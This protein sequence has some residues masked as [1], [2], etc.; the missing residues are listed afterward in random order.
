MVYV[1]QLMNFGWAM[2]GRSVPNCHLV[3]DTL[4]ELHTFAGKIGM[5][6]EW[7]QDKSIPHYDL[8]PARRAAAVARGAV[9]LNR[10]K[11]VEVI[12]RI[13]GDRR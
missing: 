1:D 4:D 5:K 6:R 2:R 3:A 11:F 8:T 10:Q 9:Q 7:F 12:R 13:R